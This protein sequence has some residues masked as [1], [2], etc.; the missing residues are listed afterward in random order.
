MRFCQRGS[1]AAILLLSL[2]LPAGASADTLID[3]VSGLTPGEGGGTERFEALLIG[4]DGRVIQL[5]K[6]GDKRPRK[7]D[8]RLDGKGRVLAPG[9]IASDVD[10]MRLGIGLLLAKPSVTR[11]DGAV[12]NG[13]PRPE[14]RDVA[15]QEAQQALL[16]S[17]FTT[18]AAMSAGIE[19]WQAFRRA[20]DMG[21][22]R[23]RLVAYAP[24]IDQTVL[25]GGPGPSPWLYEDRLKFNGPVLR[26][27]GTNGPSDTQL[28]N[29]MSR[30][31]MDRFQIA[32]RLESAAAVPV[33][34]GAAAELAE[35]YRGDRRWRV[36]GQVPGTDMPRAATLGLLA[37]SQPAVSVPADIA[38]V[39]AWLVG[40]PQGLAAN[41]AAGRALFAETRVGRLAAG[42]RADF[43]L[44]D[45]E[46]G[47][48]AT[49]GTPMPR[50]LET[51][52]GGRRAWQANDPQ[53][54]RPD[55]VHSAGR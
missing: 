26:F 21:T 55:P 35:T 15:L 2:L 9:L 51:W 36:L 19:D 8:Y 11:A 49:D 7:L 5:F 27:G 18:V 20:G 6:R 47:I 12:P 17:G 54:A 24:G 50:V 1:S 22:L 40:G 38:R 31:A 28:R 4:S 16:S 52:V 46:P 42:L 33:L 39:Q 30:A 43:V 14:D 3:N 41:A 53:P 32:I 29:L 23:M 34:L 44:L 13:Q 48:G 10:V 37:E 45:R 25:I